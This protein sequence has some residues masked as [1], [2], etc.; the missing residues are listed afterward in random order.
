MNLLFRN[1]SILA[2]SLLSC[3]LFAQ[4]RDS[5]NIKKDTQ[6]ESSFINAASDSKP[7]EISLG[8]PTNKL[9]TVMIFE[10]GLPVSCNINHLFPYK[11]WHGGVSASSSSNIGPM[12]TAMRYNE[13]NYFV[14]GINKLGNAERMKAS[15]SYTVGS[16]GQHKIDF[17]INGPISKSGWQYSLSTY[18]NFDP[19]SNHLLFTKYKDRHHFYKGVISKQ[20]AQNKG[21]MSLVYQYVNYYSIN[22]NA[23][24]FNFVGDGKVTMVDGFNLGIDQYLPRETKGRIIDAATGEMTDIDFGDNATDKS[25][26][27]TF[28]LNY[29]FDNG[30]TLDLRSRYKNAHQRSDSRS[31]ASI[32]IVDVQDGYTYADG[33]PFSGRLQTRN[34]WDYTA[35]EISWMNNV[36]IAKKHTTIN[37][38]VGADFQ[39][40]DRGDLNSSAICAHEAIANP[41]L[42]YYKGDA[43]YN[44]NSSAEYYDG[45]EYLAA[46]YGKYEWKISK[47]WNNTTFIRYGVRVL[48]GESA[49]VIGS[50]TANKRGADFSLKNAH[51]TPVEKVN[52]EWSAGSNISY[53]LNA[54]T[55]FDAE[56]IMTSIYPT[57]SDYG[58]AKLPPDSP[59]RTTL[60]RG[61]ISYSGVDF[62]ITSQVNYISQNNT[63]GKQSFPHILTKQVG[64]R[65]AGSSEMMMQSIIYSIASLGLTTDAEWSPTKEFSLHAQLML[66]N[67]KYKDFIFTPTFSDGVTENYD[68]SGNYVTSLSKVELTLDPSYSI[69]KWRVWLTARYLSKQYINKTNSLFFAGRI[70]TFGGVDY[71]LNKQIKLSLNIINLLNQKGA[72]GSINAAD[73]VEDASMYTNYVMSGKYIRP[74][75]VEFG[76]KVDL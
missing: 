53:R 27:V 23:G 52:P 50:D 2:V 67:P 68:F 12:E 65:P 60:I 6:N 41:Q 40:N 37:W 21:H 24:L 20:F 74:F 1:A 38:R 30:M 33:T 5:L 66:R 34:V 56:A 49:N 14:Y 75:T 32:D 54:R 22:E 73:L 28:A 45:M 43:F 17:N 71:K 26:H 69:N 72:S 63:V 19:G 64:N 8:L 48:D 47:R 25:H 36:E 57:L 39:I 76:V 9:G 62:S 70:E 59:T 29:N 15:V 35:H 58:I 16:F 55:Y 13:I 4:E 31:V 51:I 44:Y 10:D 46:M 42:L 11:S 61:G 7:R 18:Q 3:G